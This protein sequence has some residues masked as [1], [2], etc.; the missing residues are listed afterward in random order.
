M[1]MNGPATTTA[2]TATATAVAVVLPGGAL[3]RTIGDVSFT[4]LGARTAY[5]VK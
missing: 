4:A 3:H 5:G 2:A 1:D